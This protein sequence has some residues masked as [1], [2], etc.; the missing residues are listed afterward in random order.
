MVIE[1]RYP[2]PGHTE[3]P[4]KWVLITHYTLTH[5]SS[6]KLFPLKPVLV[7]KQSIGSFN[8]FLSCLTLCKMYKNGL[9]TAVY[10]VI[11]FLMQ[12]PEVPQKH[13]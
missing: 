5:F 11:F 8:Q 13:Y 1:H 7:L 2:R 6:F 12:D 9:M 4:G 3:S 10:Y